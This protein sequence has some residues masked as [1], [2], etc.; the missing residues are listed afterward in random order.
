MDK[1]R[2][3]PY[4]FFLYYLK[5]PLP[6]MLASVRYDESESK[7]FNTVL[8]FDNYQFGGWDIIESYPN[9]KVLY[10]MTPS[11]YSG[12]KY[13]NTFEIKDLIK[14]PNGTNAFYI[15]GAP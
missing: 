4:I 12:L 6:K 3:Q 15:V 8:S 13:I 1:I 9:Y 11:F 2:Q 7:S 5:E 14:Y 10:I